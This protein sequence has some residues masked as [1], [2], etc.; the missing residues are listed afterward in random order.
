MDKNSLRKWAKEERAKLDMKALSKRLAQ[1]L[2]NTEEYKSAKNIMI[3]YPLKDEVDLLELTNDN[4]KTF[5][6]PKID[7]D[8]LLCCK[9]DS[10]TEL[11]ESCFHT[12]EPVTEQTTFTHHPDLV[13]VPALAADKNNYRLGY[14][15]GFYDRFLSKT[16]TI[17]IVCLPKQFVVETVYPENFDIPVDRVITA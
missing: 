3:F 5:Y 2:R 6:L 11:C 10:N 1:K 14:G 8:N 4:S 17:K 13:I 15:G 7:G 9:Y 12:K 16:E